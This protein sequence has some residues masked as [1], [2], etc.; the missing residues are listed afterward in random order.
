MQVLGAGRAD[1][2]EYDCVVSNA[3]GSTTSWARDLIIN[4][5]CQLCEA[6]FNG[7]G[8]VNSQDFFDFV[9]AFFGTGPSADFNHDGVV[10]SQDF[11]DFVS[12]FFVGCSL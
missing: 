6:D 3:C 12:A 10:N 7:D 9:A 2:G 4:G 11:F 8:S 1:E 5:F